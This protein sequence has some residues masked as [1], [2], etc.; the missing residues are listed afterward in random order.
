[1]SGI[2]VNLMLIILYYWIVILE[3]SPAISTVVPT[4]RPWFKPTFTMFVCVWGGGGGGGVLVCIHYVRIH[5]LLW[6]SGKK[7][8]RQAQ[9]TQAHN[10]DFILNENEG[11]K[12]AKKHGNEK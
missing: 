1:M 8:C 5:C 2:S 12:T 6:D 4:L 7:I 10:E 9:G 3:M 11:K